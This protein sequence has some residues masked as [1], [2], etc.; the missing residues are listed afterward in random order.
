MY[1]ELISRCKINFKPT[2]QKGGKNIKNNVFDFRSKDSELQTKRINKKKIILL[3]VIILSVIASISL[4]VAYSLNNE[5]RDFWDYTVLRKEVESTDVKSIALEK[6]VLK[7]SHSYNNKIVIL[8]NNLL[9]SYNQE[10]NKEW[11]LD[12]NIANPLYNDSNRFLAIAEKDGKK[13]YLINENNL[14]WQKDLEGNIFQIYVN[15]NG[16]VGVAMSTTGYKTVIVLYNPSGEEMFRTYLPTTYCIDMEISNDNKYMAIAEL[17]SSGTMIETSIKI[18]SIENA[19]TKPQEAFI[20][21]YNPNSNNMILNI[22]YT[23]DGK[24]IAMY[25]NA[26]YYAHESMEEILK[27]SS[28]VIFA[29]IES[30][31]RVISIEKQSGGLLNIDYV[32]KIY[33]TNINKTFEYHLKEVPKELYVKDNVI[34]ISHGTDV[35][36]VSAQSGWLIKKYV[37]RQD[38]KDVLISNGFVAIEYNSEIKII[39]I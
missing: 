32:L 2:I 14:A 27:V 3:V 34:A 21:T 24:L 35:E 18:I 15:K 36:I 13:L 29:D 16:Y 22:K 30:P 39:K 11:E 31:N 38:I 9:E 17:D 23:D 8:E 4:L 12:I 6:D 19:K 33:N 28:N 37:S 5:F 7:F 26:I 25:D 20:A 1:F 10:G